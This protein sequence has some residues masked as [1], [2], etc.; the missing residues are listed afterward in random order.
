MEEVRPDCSWL[1]TSIVG[2]SHQNLSQLAR[3]RH[4]LKISSTKGD[5]IRKG[6][7]HYMVQSQSDISKFYA[8]VLTKDGWTCE[9]RTTNISSS[10]CDVKP[11]L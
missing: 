6:S 1:V 10:K 7:N 11:P 5:V 4:G 9:C 8:V 2:E 3:I